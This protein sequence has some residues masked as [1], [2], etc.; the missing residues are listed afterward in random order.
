VNE[1]A[2]T[3]GGIFL[4]VLLSFPLTLLMYT[5]MGISSIFFGVL[6]FLIT[7]VYFFMY[8]HDLSRRTYQIR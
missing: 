3:Y 8:L 1:V 4:L 5:T 7:R 2:S 6:S